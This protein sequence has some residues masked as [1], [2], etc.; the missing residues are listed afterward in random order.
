[1]PVTTGLAYLVGTQNVFKWLP[2]KDG[3][4]TTSEYQSICVFSLPSCVLSRLFCLVDP[5]LAFV[6][7]LS[8]T[9]FSPLAFH[10]LPFI[11]LFRLILSWTTNPSRSR[12]LSYTGDGRSG[13]H[14]L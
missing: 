3:T 2:F 9:R 13:L 1:M 5:A 6:E 14:E 11:N 8:T 10:V 4:N 7:P 12:Y